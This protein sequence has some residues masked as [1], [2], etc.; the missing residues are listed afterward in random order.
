[1][2]FRSNNQGNNRGNKNQGYNNQNA[3]KG[4]QGKHPHGGKYNPPQGGP[5]SSS[6]SAGQNQGI[7]DY[8]V[9]SS[10]ILNLPD[11]ASFIS[12]VDTLSTLIQD[13]YLHDPST[14]P[15]NY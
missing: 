14:L 5:H 2:L 10:D 3:G 8:D 15:S 12:H 1:M 13:E 4:Y 11:V 7:N 9:H 6:D